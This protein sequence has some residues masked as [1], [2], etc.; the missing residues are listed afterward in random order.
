EAGEGRRRVG[1]IPAGDLLDRVHQVPGQVPE[2]RARQLRGRVPGRT[3][4]VGRPKERL[5]GGERVAVGAEGDRRVTADR[6]AGGGED[7]VV[8]GAVTED[9]VAP[10][11]V[12]GDDA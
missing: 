3:A 5:G 2:G 9:R 11:A 12:A 8:A 1:S 7:R 4:G 10:P 6:P